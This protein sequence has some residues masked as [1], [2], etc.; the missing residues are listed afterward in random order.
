MLQRARRRRPVAVLLSTGP[1][2]DVAQYGGRS[3]GEGNTVVR[4]R[5]W[6]VGVGVGLAVAGSVVFVVAAGQENRLP[7][8]TVGAQTPAGG[9]MPQTREGLVEAWAAELKRADKTLPE[10][11][12]MLTTGEIRGRYIHQKITNDGPPKDIDP[13]FNGPVGD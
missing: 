3:F 9:L 10:G 13:G 12:E 4:R 2:G 7:P 6:V 1:C 5:T 8:V 11:W